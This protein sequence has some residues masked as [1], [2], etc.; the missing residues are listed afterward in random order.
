MPPPDDECVPCQKEIICGR[1]ANSLL[2]MA[3]GMVTS[4][5]WSEEKTRRWNAHLDEFIVGAEE[6]ILDEQGQR[7][8]EEG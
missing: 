3:H 8:L 6:I 2:A 7:A 4:G 1:K 5:A